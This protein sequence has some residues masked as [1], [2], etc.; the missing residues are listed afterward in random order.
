[1]RVQIWIGVVV[2]GLV[3]ACRSDSP[4]ADDRCDP[5]PCLHEGACAMAVDEADE[6]VCSCAPGYEGPLCSFES[7]E[8]AAQ[9]CMNGGEC[10]DRI[11]GYSCTCRDGFEGESCEIDIDDCEGVSCLNG[12]TCV[13]QQAGHHCDCVN[14]YGGD[15]CETCE[16][17]ATTSFLDQADLVTPMLDVGELTITG[18][19]AIHRTSYGIGVVGGDDRLLD[20]EEWLRVELDVATTSI[21]YTIWLAI[22]QDGD[23]QYVECE[24][25]AFDANGI[26]LGTLP[27]YEVAGELSAAYG[28]VPIK[29]FVVRPLGDGLSFGH[30]TFAA[31]P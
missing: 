16:V 18:S 21:S 23:E 3:A 10:H 2:L 13:D 31:C 26:S 25:E 27:W 24:F 6:I 22:N 5:N 14:G 30:F 29:A 15:A 17:L 9:P 8:C 12:G 1:M 19:A 20:G 11:A 4:I 28:G 7:D